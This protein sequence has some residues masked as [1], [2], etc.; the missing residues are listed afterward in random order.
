MGCGRTEPEHYEVRYRRTFPGRN[1]C[2]EL[3][4]HWW[5]PHLGWMS[6]RMRKR[7]IPGTW[8][9]RRVAQVAEKWRQGR[10]A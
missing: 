9:E 6:S 7:W 8:S 4:E 5:T 10:E 2:V 3:I 1:W